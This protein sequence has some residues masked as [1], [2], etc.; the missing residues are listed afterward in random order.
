MAWLERSL[1]ASAVLMAALPAA[2]TSYCC[3]DENGWRI[4]GDVVVKAYEGPLTA[5]QRALRE[6]EQARLKATQRLADEERRRDQALRAS[7]GSIKDIDAKRDRML[8]EAQASLLA[9]QQRYDEAVARRKHLEEEMEFYAK[10][11]PPA[12]L[13][14]QIRDNRAELDSFESGLAARKQEMDAIR[15]RFEEEKQRYIKLTGRK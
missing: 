12:S 9:A 13:V 14:A 1:L 8:A 11:A 4:C 2:A 5:E 15:A 10:K 6:A 7:Y 3:S